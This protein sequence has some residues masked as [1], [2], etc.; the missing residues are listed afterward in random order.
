MFSDCDDDYSF[1]DDL[2]YGSNSETSETPQVCVLELPVFVLN[3]CFFRHRV[4]HQSF[5]NFI[6]S[7]ISSE[8]VL[9]FNWYMVVS[10]W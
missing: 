4:I 1:D 7:Q 8:I 10:R 2:E 9:T 5:T 6:W 3:M